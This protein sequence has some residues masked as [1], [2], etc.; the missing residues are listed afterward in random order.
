MKNLWNWLSGKKSVIAG[1]LAL[2]IGFLQVK[3]V[4]DEQ[5]ATFLLSLSAL[6]LGVGVVHKIKKSIDK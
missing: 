1:I 3:H 2:T 6:L 4:L 5:T